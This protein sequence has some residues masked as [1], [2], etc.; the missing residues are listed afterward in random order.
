M[1]RAIIFGKYLRNT[2]MEVICGTLKTYLLFP[3]MP[4]LV[5]IKYPI[6]K[7]E[8]ELDTSLITIVQ[9]SSVI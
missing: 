9:I 3:A 6:E 1:D 4:K 2:P 7:F 5:V 8:K